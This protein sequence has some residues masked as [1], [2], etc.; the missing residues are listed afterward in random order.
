MKLH[1]WVSLL[2]LAIQKRPC[3]QLIVRLIHIPM[4]TVRRRQNMIDLLR[5][6]RSIRKYTQTP[7]DSKTIDALI[8]ALL[9]SPTSRNGKSWE[10]VIVDDRDL[11]SKLSQTREQGSHHL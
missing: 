11:L 3:I 5:T 8:E 2:E 6:R 10:F 7:I 9:R 1:R 4:S